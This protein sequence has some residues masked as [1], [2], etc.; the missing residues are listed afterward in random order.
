[1]IM[2]ED[3]KTANLLLEHNTFENLG[4]GFGINLFNFDL[5]AND[6]D[7]RGELDNNYLG[8]LVYIKASF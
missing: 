4:I 3:F 6:G 2:T 7:F 1:M 8:F 5:T